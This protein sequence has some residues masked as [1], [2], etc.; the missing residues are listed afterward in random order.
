MEAG[1]SYIEK[2]DAAEQLE[3]GLGEVPSPPEPEETDDGEGDTEGSNDE[4]ARET[5]ERI[6]KESEKEVQEREP[7]QEAKVSTQKDVRAKQAQAPVDLKPP[8][9]LTA[10]E[11]EVFNQAPPQI[12]Q[13]ISKM[14]AQHEAAFTKGR[15]AQSAAENESRHIVEAIRPYMQANPHLAQN[16]YTESRLVAELIGTHQA[17]TNPKTAKQTW[18]NIGR[19]IGIDSETLEA[20][21]DVG[22]S[23]SGSQNNDISNHPQFQAVQK[24][25]NAIKSYIGQQTGEKQSQ[26]AQSIL[27]EMEAVR[28]EIDPA[29]NRYLYPELHD[30]GFIERVKPLVS[31]LVQS[32]P[33]IGYG[34]ALKRAYYS[35]KGNFPQPS[36]TKLP[37]QNNNINKKAA[38]AAISVRGKV[39]PTSVATASTDIPKEALG[40]ARDSVKWALNQLR[41]G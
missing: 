19:Q 28:D 24:E 38:S 34:E 13:A 7:S 23:G 25:L 3:I 26:V 39:P 32:S 17:L 8:T 27:S 40:S 21:L 9:R 31:A 4:T 11:K 41:Q 29:T 35:I 2:V 18:A 33:D 30:E 16:G 22:S 5:V 20:L 14:L 15:Q 12:K 36:Q 1:S 37:A 10:E 6:L